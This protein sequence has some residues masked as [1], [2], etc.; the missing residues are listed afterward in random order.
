MGVH[1]IKGGLLITSSVGP[2]GECLKLV[3]SNL[4]RVK[5]THHMSPDA[6][7]CTLCVGVWMADLFIQYTIR[8]CTVSLQSVV[9]IHTPT[10]RVH[11][12]ASGDMW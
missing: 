7:A 1:V 11:A 4:A 5:R 6:L 10:Q 8:T 12:R 3:L 9:T 2:V